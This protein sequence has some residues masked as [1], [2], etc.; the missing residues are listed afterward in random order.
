MIC[1]HDQLCFV[2]LAPRRL[3]LIHGRRN[4]DWIISTSFLVGLEDNRPAILAKDGQHI[5]VLAHVTS[6]PQPPMLPASPLP[7]FSKTAWD[8]TEQA[9]TLRQRMIQMQLRAQQLEDEEASYQEMV[10]STSEV[11]EPD[12]EKDATQ[13]MPGS[14]HEPQQ[15]KA[16]A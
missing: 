15:K 14:P 10:S 8:L 1:S 2:G 11:S 12:L 6:R 3:N 16:K 7:N 4:R 5:A 13:P 9:E